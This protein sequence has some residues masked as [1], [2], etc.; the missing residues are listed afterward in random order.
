MEYE[1]AIELALLAGYDGVEIQLYDFPD[2][3][4]WKNHLINALYQSGM[5]ATIH[6]PSGDINLSSSNRGIREE[7]LRQ[8]KETIYLAKELGALSVTVHPGRLS[9][10]REKKAQQ[11]LWMEEAFL[12]IIEFA[13]KEQVFIGFENME[14]RAKETYIYLEHIN[15][16]LDKKQ[17]DFSGITL[18]FAH[19]YTV[20]P[21][22]N[23]ASLRYPIQN[24]HISQCVQGKPHFRL[25]AAEGQLSISSCLRALQQIGYDKTVVIEAKDNSSFEDAKRNLQL[26]QNG[27]FENNRGK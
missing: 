8:I 4:R 15:Q 7:S 13:E 16:L 26:L 19:L 5:I 17:S 11:I 27:L 14:A 25:D 24:V 6:S 21:T 23:L 12:S 18:D 10:V 9:S 1:K 22:L 2:G 3:I 20:D